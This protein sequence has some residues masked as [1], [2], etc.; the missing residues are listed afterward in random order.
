MS[1]KTTPV[2]LE[3][4]KKRQAEYERKVSEFRAE[5]SDSILTGERFDKS[6]LHD[7]ED[8]LG[9]IKEAIVEFKRREEDKRVAEAEVEAAKTEQE[10]LQAAAAG[11]RE[12]AASRASAIEAAEKAA[13]AF[14]KAIVEAEEHRRNLAAETM[15]L[16]GTMPLGLM[17]GGQED[18]MSKAFAAVLKAALGKGSFGEIRLNSGLREA[19]QV[20]LSSEAEVARDIKAGLV[21]I[22]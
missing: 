16:F 6:K 19:N 14:G 8:E 10:Y 4:L 22:E 11:V 1:S 18:R 7:A 20:W 17:Q 9:A 13:R 5:R 2:G 21:A 12:L 15:R 3:T